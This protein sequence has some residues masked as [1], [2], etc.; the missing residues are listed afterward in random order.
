[1]GTLSYVQLLPYA[2]QL[3]AVAIILTNSISFAITSY[4][5]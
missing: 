2:I 4:S 3:V 1:M 5:G